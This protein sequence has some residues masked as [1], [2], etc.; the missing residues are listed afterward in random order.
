MFGGCLQRQMG[1]I[2]C[3]GKVGGARIWHWILDCAET[4]GAEV[5]VYFCFEVARWRRAAGSGE[6][7]H[8]GSHIMVLCLLNWYESN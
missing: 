5:V 2:D 1:V 7:E 8:G 3:L 4:F 6:L